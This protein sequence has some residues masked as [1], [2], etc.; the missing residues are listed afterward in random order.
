M[1][2]IGH[3]GKIRAAAARGPVSAVFGSRARGAVEWPPW[4]LLQRAG[5]SPVFIDGAAVVCG[6]SGSLRPLARVLS[7]ALPG[8]DLDRGFLS[9]A[10]SL[11]FSLL[12]FLEPLSQ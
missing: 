1:S 11:C 6:Y 7:R 5:R 4:L 12:P 9:H 8:S 2:Y 10:P 3:G